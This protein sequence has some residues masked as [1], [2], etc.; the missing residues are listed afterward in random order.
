MKKATTRRSFSETTIPTKIRTEFQE[1]VEVV[2]IVS[3]KDYPKN[4]RR[5]LWM[6]SDELAFSMHQA[7]ILELKERRERS[8][9]ALQ[10]PDIETKGELHMLA[11]DDDSASDEEGSL[12][13]RDLAMSDGLALNE[14]HPGMDNVLEEMYEITFSQQAY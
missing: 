14:S 3:F 5:A 11:S 2:P 10:E 4:V 1:D 6:S 9:D 13:Y 7:K 8:L 12:D